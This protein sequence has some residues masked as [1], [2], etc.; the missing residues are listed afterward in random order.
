MAKRIHIEIYP[1]F[2]TDPVDLEFAEAK[3]HSTTKFTMVDPESGQQLVL[4][5]SGFKY[6]DEGLIKAGTVT[7]FAIN[8]EDRD[9]I[10]TITDMSVKLKPYFTGESNSNTAFNLLISVITGND[11]DFRG[12]NKG[13]TIQTFV[14]NDILDGRKG[15]DQLDG[16]SGNDILIGGKG[17]DTFIF[18][19]GDGRDVIRDF[20]PVAAGGQDLIAVE[21][22][23][24]VSIRKSGKHDTILDFGG[25]DRVLLIGVNPSQIDETDFTQ[26]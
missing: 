3:A 1:A 20:D 9:P 16:G 23:D 12:S 11:L 25:G 19:E 6:T 18:D 8:N 4:R 13:D 2:Y 5:G 10:E 14:G 21:N 26:L 7:S 15:H 17:S 24:D 22:P